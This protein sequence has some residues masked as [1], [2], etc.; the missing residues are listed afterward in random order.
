MAN[1]MDKWVAHTTSYRQDNTRKTHNCPVPGYF[2][3]EAW[4]ARY[5]F[6]KIGGCTLP[7][8]QSL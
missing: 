4:Q 1:G 5:N 7:V 2:L 3:P 8:G 6:G